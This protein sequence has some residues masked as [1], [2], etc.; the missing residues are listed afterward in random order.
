MKILYFYPEHEGSF[1]FF[2]QRIHFIEELSYYGIDIE[3]LNPLKYGS[4][5]ESHEVL[6]KK[7]SSTH[8]DL[9]F[10]SSSLYASNDLLSTIRRLGIPSLCFR[11]DNLLIPYI[12]KDIAPSFDLVWLTSSDTEHLYKKWGVHYFFAP[13]AANP[14]TFTPSYQQLIRKVGFIGTPYGS[15]TNMINSVVNAQ[16]DIDVY[17]KNNTDQKVNS[18][19]PKY[20]GPSM[21]KKEVLLN[22][23]RFK[24]GRKV[25][26]ANLLNRLQHHELNEGSECLQL[27]PKVPFEELNAIYSNYSLSLS[28]TSARNTDILTHPVNVINLRA[29]EIPMAGGLQFCRYCKE[30]ACYFE[31][32]KEIVFYR[33]K[34]ELADKAKYYSTKASESELMMMKLAARRRAEG[35]HSWINRF[36]QAFDILGLKHK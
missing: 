16:V 7:I 34:E 15:R 4:I 27:L 20:Q 25:M 36:N 10:M 11:P 33:T 12:D 19:S 28:S 35:E 13:Y 3:I 6:L 22:N 8:Y 29:F 1:M 32:D 9:F 24:E 2:W 21:S 30:L 31:E 18:F 23:I 17:C 14:K 5:E 26:Y